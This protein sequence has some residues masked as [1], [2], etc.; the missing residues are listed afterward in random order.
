[1]GADRNAEFTEV[2]RK[3]A[4]SVWRICARYF[5]DQADRE[6]AFQSTFVRYVTKNPRFES[7]EHCRAWLLRVAI[8]ICKDIL[9]SSAHKEV[10]IGTFADSA[11]PPHFDDMPQGLEAS[12]APPGQDD[13]TADVRTALEQLPETYKTPLYLTYYEGFPAA[14]IAELLDQP[15]NTVYSNIARGRKALKEVLGNGRA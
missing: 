2:I 1:M 10:L 7:D 4:D 14:K 5:S 6:D 8:N 15:V 9:K 3:H 12:G 13:R 11:L